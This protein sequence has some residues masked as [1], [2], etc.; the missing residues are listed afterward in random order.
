MEEHDACNEHKNFL[1]HISN[2][3]GI[4]TR[5]KS[6]TSNEQCVGD[7]G[8]KNLQKIFTKKTSAKTNKYE[9]HLLLRTRSLISVASARFHRQDDSTR[10]RPL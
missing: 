3:N 10:I 2:Y 6:N 5:V 1:W 7:D 8:F 4:Q 9:L